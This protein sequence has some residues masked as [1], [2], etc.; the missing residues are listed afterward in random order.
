MIH[1]SSE[2]LLVHLAGCTGTLKSFNFL[3]PGNKCLPTLLSPVNKTIIPNTKKVL[4][5][6]LELF[7]VSGNK[8]EKEPYYIVTE[9]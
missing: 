6:T 3:R 2:Y 7:I 9:I 8:A 4:I 5:I 1:F